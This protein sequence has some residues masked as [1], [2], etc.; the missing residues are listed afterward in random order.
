MKPCL[1]TPVAFMVFNRPHLTRRVFE[2]IAKA[3]PQQL[4]V[5]ADGPRYREEASSC[6]EVRAVIEEVNWDCDVLTNFSEQN[7]GC[8]K[9]ISS[10]LEWIFSQ[11]EEAIILEDDCLPA[12]SFFGFCQALLEYYRVDNRIMH[13]SGNNCQLRI[14][15]TE[16]SYYFSKYP[17]AWGWATWKRAWKYYD[18][19][20]ISWPEFKRTG[21]LELICEDAREIEY[22]EEIF[23][24]TF[25]GLLDTWDYQWIYACWCQN[26]LSI[27]P[28]VN[29]VSNIGFGG[30][31]THTHRATRLSQLST[32][33][34]SVLK[35]PRF[36]V[37]HRKADQYEFGYSWG[38]KTDHNLKEALMAALRLALSRIRKKLEKR[39]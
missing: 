37:R 24:R 27:L 36:T 38:P 12:E 35:H 39:S 22:W 6:E 14:N 7:M 30:G 20:M 4:L 8:R 33:E 5:V 23:D 32:S 26:G 13:I 17:H 21:M 3:R 28:N 18:V 15:R 2:R 16:S 19:H 11:V 25:A 1:K 31:G 34:I 10:G 29:L 9:R